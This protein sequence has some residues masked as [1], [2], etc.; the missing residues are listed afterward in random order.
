MENYFGGSSRSDGDY[1]FIRGC[2]NGYKEA[3]G[4]QI[5]IATFFV[6]SNRIR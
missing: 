3:F 4:K 5:L 6:L 2:V 1:M